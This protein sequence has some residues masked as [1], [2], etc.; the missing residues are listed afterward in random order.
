M[1]HD[2][3]GSLPFFV[4]DLGEAWNIGIRLL[5]L[6]G[7]DEVTIRAEVSRQLFAIFASGELVPGWA[8]AW[9]IPSSNARPRMTRMRAPIVKPP[10]VARLII[11]AGCIDVGTLHSTEDEMAGKDAEMPSQQALSADIQ[12]IAKHLAALRK[13]LEA[14]TG[15]I[16]RTGDHQ[17]E[18]VQDTAGEALKAVEDAVRQN[19]FSSLGIA[20]GVGFLVGIV[21]RR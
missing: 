6:A 13:D 2:R 18:R 8:N 16:R 20:L 17:L 19:P 9:A 7:A 1:R 5:L 10:P 12:E 21:L 11:D 4:S 15:Q 14:L 3:A